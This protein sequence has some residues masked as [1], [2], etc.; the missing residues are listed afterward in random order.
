VLKL[1]YNFCRTLQI[2][3]EKISTT[4]IRENV[5]NI[6][7]KIQNENGAANTVK[8]ITDYFL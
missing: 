3:L 5:E 6:G 8:K 4:G 1:S 2:F 7:N